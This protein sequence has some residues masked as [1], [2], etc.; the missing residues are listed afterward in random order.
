VTEPTPTAANGE[1]IVLKA[2][3]AF[4]KCNMQAAVLEKDNTVSIGI[5]DLKKQAAQAVEDGY[6]MKGAMMRRLA[7]KFEK[8]CETTES[9]DELEFQNH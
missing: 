8:V 3:V 1:K 6:N 9:E 4:N 7:L 2:D 5:N